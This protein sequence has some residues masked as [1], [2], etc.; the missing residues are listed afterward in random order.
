MSSGL[1]EQRPPLC[2]GLFVYN[3]YF[4]LQLSVISISINHCLTLSDIQMKQKIFRFSVLFDDM[5]WRVGLV[6]SHPT[7]LK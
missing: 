6:V 4:I 2:I 7:S 3:P 1:L 5:G